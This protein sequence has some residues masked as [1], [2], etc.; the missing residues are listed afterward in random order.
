MKR[1]NKEDR[2]ARFGTHPIDPAGD[3]DKPSTSKS[4]GWGERRNL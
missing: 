1:I 2:A 3:S 4:G